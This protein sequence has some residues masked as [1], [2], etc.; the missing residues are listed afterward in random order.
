[1]ESNE[2]ADFHAHHHRVRDH[3]NPA[4]FGLLR[5]AS[6]HDKRKLDPEQSELEPY[7]SYEPEAHT[8]GVQDMTLLDLLEVLAEIRAVC[9][10]LTV[11]SFARCLE[12]F[13]QNYKVPEDLAGLLRR[14]AIEFFWCDVDELTEVRKLLVDG[15]RARA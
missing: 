8:R 1:M 15:A 12:V 4:I 13:I 11:V 14:S 7:S 9:E 2:L 10:Q 6:V 5:R 3:L